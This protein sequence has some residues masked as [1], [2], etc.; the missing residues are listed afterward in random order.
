MLYFHR[1]ETYSIKEMYVI[2]SVNF[3]EKGCSRYMSSTKSSN[4]FHN[5]YRDPMNG[6][7]TVQ[8]SGKVIKA[9]NSIED[10]YIK[11]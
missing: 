10:G 4:A 11:F 1:E 7:K 8:Y 3:L 5:V 6:S 9:I 2:S